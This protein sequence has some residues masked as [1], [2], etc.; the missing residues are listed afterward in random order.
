MSENKAEGEVYP[1]RQENNQDSQAFAVGHTQQR[2]EIVKNLLP[3]SLETNSVE[4][5][6]EYKPSIYSTCFIS[7]IGQGVIVTG[8]TWNIVVG[9][10]FF[11]VGLVTCIVKELAIEAVR[12][13]DLESKDELAQAITLV[14]DGVKYAVRPY[15]Y[16]DSYKTMSQ[17]SLK[18]A[19]G[20]QNAFF[21]NIYDYGKGNNI[22]VV[23]ALDSALPLYLANDDSEVQKELAGLRDN[24]IAGFSLEA[25]CRFIL[26][27]FAGVE[28]DREK[29]SLSNIK[30]FFVSEVLSSS[31]DRYFYGFDDSILPDSMNQSSG[32]MW[33]FQTSY[34]CENKLEK[35]SD[36]YGN[37]ASHVE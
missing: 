34:S 27:P 20:M 14:A 31:Y 11:G 13:S 16:D 22:W 2:D 12:G 29:D 6:G 25:F 26:F 5:R 33:N 35:F 32:T 37:F 15:F 23:E 21:H 24:L 28:L 36:N 17:V 18:F 4:P 19:I 1:W 3:A 30:S 9:S 8:I 10:S 7:S